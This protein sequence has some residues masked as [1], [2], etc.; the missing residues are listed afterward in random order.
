MPWLGRMPTI[1][2][3]YP[4]REAGRHPMRCSQTC[5]G[6]AVVADRRRE[7]E[8]ESTRRMRELYAL[9]REQLPER[10]QLLAGQ[11]AILLYLKQFGVTQ[12]SKR[13]VTWTTVRRWVRWHDFPLTPGTRW[14]RNYMSAITTTYAITARLLSRPYNGHPMRVFREPHP[15]SN[16]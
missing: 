4:G 15:P 13:P 5:V 3:G 12:W 1:A 9:M 10:D 11:D 14:G 6:S 7:R 16:R 2:F 8:D